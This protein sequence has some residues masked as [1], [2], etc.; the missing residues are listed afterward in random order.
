MIDK[1]YKILERVPRSG[2]MHFVLF[3]ALSAGSLPLLSLLLGIV[4]GAIVT[5]AACAALGFWLALRS[6]IR[7]DGRM[8]AMDLAYGCAGCLAVCLSALALNF[9]PV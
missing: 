4:P 5:S 2:W 9:L 8:N 7:N 6:H 3:A 1:I